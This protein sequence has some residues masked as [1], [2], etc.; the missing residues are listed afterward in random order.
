MECESEDVYEDRFDDESFHDA[1]LS[2]GESDFDEN[3]LR[4]ADDYAKTEIPSCNEQQENT[5]ERGIDRLCKQSDSHYPITLSTIAEE[6]DSSSRHGIRNEFSFGGISESN[7]SRHGFNSTDFKNQ[8]NLLELMERAELSYNKRTGGGNIIEGDER[9]L[10]R[11]NQTHFNKENSWEPSIRNSPPPLPSTFESPPK[12]SILGEIQDLHIP[13]EIRE[14]PINYQKKS[15]TTVSDS[16]TDSNMES[17]FASTPNSAYNG[18]RPFKQI[19]NSFTMKFID[20][21]E[22]EPSG[23]TN[24]DSSSINI[25][26]A[27]RLTSD[28]DTPVALH[29]SIA[30]SVAE[31]TVDRSRVEQI[32]KI[33]SP[34]R[35][36]RLA[37]LNIGKPQ[38]S[39][40]KNNE[41]SRS[42]RPILYN[43]SQILRGEPCATRSKSIMRPGL[44]VSH[45]E[46]LVS[47][48]ESGTSS[49]PPLTITREVN[50]GRLSSMSN[51]SEKRSP[52]HIPQ[53]DVAFGFVAIG[54]TALATLRMINRL[55]TPLRISTCLRNTQ[56]A[57]T[58]V[59]LKKF[60]L[61]ILLVL[62][63]LDPHIHVLDPGREL[64]I[65]VE[66]SP[67]KPARYNTAISVKILSGVGKSYTDVSFVKVQVHGSGGV[68]SIRI[69]YSDELYPS[70]SGSFILNTSSERTLRFPL[71]NKGEREAF[72]H[73]RMLSQ[74]GVPI[75]DIEI[76]PSDSLVIKR[77]TK[78]NI[79]IRLRSLLCF[80]YP[81]DWRSSITSLASTGSGQSIGSTATVTG[82]SNLKIEI[83]WGEET[84][85]QR[86][87]G[88]ERKSGKA[89]LIEGISFSTPF[90]GEQENFQVPDNYPV[91]Y[92]DY[93]LFGTLL[94]T[95]IIYVVSSRHSVR[96][97]LL[98]DNSLSQSLQP[99]STFRDRTTLGNTVVPDVTLV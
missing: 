81:T 84:I 7:A 32:I 58:V 42:D 79:T 45:R 88:L 25:F 48:S 52:L 18:D 99:D 92:S 49:R 1:P 94:R 80:S 38:E 77:G 37:S 29:G 67:T 43:E 33:C 13:H 75:S 71:E 55:E 63:I 11:F 10:C 2:D 68:A 34:K 90:V 39:C 76:S 65:R 86:L 4:S 27:F 14:T 93:R 16:P 8:G 19:R 83:F 22:I 21:S 70:R 12:R 20:L 26:P 30:E 57:F 54:D 95:H 89:F 91:S 69:P 47:R 87:K 66:F 35:G 98:S 53:Q 24:V 78:I 9:L 50:S 60:K 44:K 97:S 82:R 17:H 46:S 74:A 23:L 31:S 96:Q 61:L 3:D 72:V 41:N 28:K 36:P 62:Q 5:S 85:R 15:L 40:E 64:T 51:A 73:I 59:T 6:L 56:T